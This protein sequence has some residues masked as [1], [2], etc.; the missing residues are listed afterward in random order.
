[1][2]DVDVR[3]QHRL[4]NGLALEQAGNRGQDTAC[5]EFGSGPVVQNLGIKRRA[6]A[7][8]EGW[9]D[10]PEPIIVRAGEAFIAVPAPEG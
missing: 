2:F 5:D 4:A 6:S 9:M 8:A 1:M 10:L 3:E 7:G